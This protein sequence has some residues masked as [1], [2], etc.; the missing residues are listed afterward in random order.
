MGG[1]KHEEGGTDL[2]SRLQRGRLNKSKACQKTFWTLCLVNTISSSPILVPFL[3]VGLT[4]FKLL[5]QKAHEIY[6]SESQIF[7]SC[8]LQYLFIIFLLAA[9]FWEGSKYV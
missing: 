9:Y 7:G 2:R 1:R 4:A 8:A 3:A 5:M 6:T